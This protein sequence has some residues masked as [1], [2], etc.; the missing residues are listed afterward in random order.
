[1]VVLNLADDAAQV[2]AA[3]A[4]RVLAGSAEVLADGVRVPGHGWAVLGG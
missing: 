3:G 2:P 1:M 4:G